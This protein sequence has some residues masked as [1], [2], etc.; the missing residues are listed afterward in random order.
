MSF[1]FGQ[2]IDDGLV[3]HGQKDTDEVR[4]YIGAIT[5]INGDQG[6]LHMHY[7]KLTSLASIF[8]ER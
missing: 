3:Y 2:M 6:E 4:I 8:S 5:T 1:S 7:A